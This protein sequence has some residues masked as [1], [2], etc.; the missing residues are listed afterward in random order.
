MV[1]I[2]SPADSREVLKPCAFI[3]N[4]DAMI[5]LGL[6]AAQCMVPGRVIPTVMVSVDELTDIVSSD[7]EGGIGIKIGKVLAKA[8]VIDIKEVAIAGEGHDV[9]EG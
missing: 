1:T 7:E 2:A 6:N 5:K 4:T 8:T 3:S 9:E